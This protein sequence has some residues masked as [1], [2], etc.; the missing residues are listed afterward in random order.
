M[1]FRHSQLDT[2]ENCNHT[3]LPPALLPGVSQ[4]C[5][6][7]HDANNRICLVEASLTASNAH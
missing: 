5:F 2:G 7:L 4:N 3:L 1:R 6:L